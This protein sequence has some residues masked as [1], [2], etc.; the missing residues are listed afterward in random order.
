VRA[1][2]K[3]LGGFLV[4]ARRERIGML[5]ETAQPERTVDRGV[6]RLEAADRDFR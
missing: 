2:R 1:L 6:G 5:G 4:M 3:G